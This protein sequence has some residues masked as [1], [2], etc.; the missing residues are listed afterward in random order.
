MTYDLAV[1]QR[2]LASEMRVAS[3][4]V[5]LPD[6]VAELVHVAEQTEGVHLSEL[7]TALQPDPRAAEDA[8]AQVLRAAAD[9]PAEADSD[10]A[11]HM[12][13]W[14][15]VIAAIAAAS[16]GD[17]DATTELLPFLD[18]LAERPDWA[19]LVRA[20]RRILDGDRD[21]EG[22]AV[23]LD[24]IDAAIVGRTLD[25]IADRA[26]L[27]PSVDEQWLPVIS[28]IVAA[29]SGEREVSAELNRLLDQLAGTSDWAALVAVLR[30]ILAGER[31]PSQLTADLSA[32]DAIDSAIVDQVLAG[33]AGQHSEQLEAW[34]ARKVADRSRRSADEIM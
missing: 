31:D 14:E 29:A 21:R 23:G 26:Q 6:T 30:R 32:M 10:I 8:L 24:A 28:D 17:Q 2:A 12:Q 34:R 11:R 15:P 22:L 5:V 9:L 33:L 7:V 20:L 16:Q 13:Q 25:V 4:D 27:T 3:S 1:T 18:D 19:A